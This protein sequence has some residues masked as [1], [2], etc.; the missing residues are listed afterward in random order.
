[1]DLKQLKERY[2]ILEKKYFLPSFQK[3]N[4]DFE[5]DKIER[6]SDTFLRVVRK[7]MMEKIVN[8]LGFL[9][10]L[11]NPVNAP[12]I[13]LSY[14]KSMTQKDKD[15]LN[16]LYSNLGELSL[17]F[18]RLE[19]DYSEKG[20]ADAINKISSVWNKSKDGFRVI[21]VDIVKPGN[22]VLKKEKSYFG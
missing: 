12:R 9:E 21:M 15:L 6:E 20:E 8:S 10:M 2:Q 18:L 11:V 22:D 14:V 5:I 17:E 13:Y 1:M 7:T 4:E 3:L 16:I 19:I